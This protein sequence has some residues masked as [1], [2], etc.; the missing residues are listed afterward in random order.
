MAS[1]QDMAVSGTETAEWPIQNGSQPFDF[2]SGNQMAY[3]KGQG[4]F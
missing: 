3:T 1:F 4:I 2:W